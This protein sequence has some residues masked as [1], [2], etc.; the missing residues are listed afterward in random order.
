MRISLSSYVLN[1]ASKYGGASALI[2][3]GVTRVAARM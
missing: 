1:I 3:E 2:V